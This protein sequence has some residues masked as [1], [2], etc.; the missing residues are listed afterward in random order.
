[1]TY[2]IRL[3]LLLTLFSALFSFQSHAQQQPAVQH[4]HDLFQTIE[5]AYQRGELNL[6]QKVLYQFYA[7][8]Q[9]TRLPAEFKPAGDVIMKCGTPAMTSFINNRDQLSPATINQVESM[10]RTISPQSSESYQSSSGKFTIHYQTSGSGAV[11]P[12]DQNNNG[13]PDYVEE[14]A[15]AADSSYRHEVQR[16]GYT[17]AIVGNSD[18]YPIFIENTS[19]NYGFTDLGYRRNLKSDTFI[20]VHN[21][22]ENF[23]ENDDPEGDQI[24]SLKVTIAHELKHA[25]Q[26]EANQWQGETERWL[27]MDATLMEEVVYDD[28][29]DYYNYLASEQSIFNSPGQN[30]Y[31]GSYFHVSWALYF[32]ERYGSQ[33][34]VDVWEIIKS[35]PSI[36]M[37]NALTQQLGGQEAFARNFT[38][39]QLWHLAAGA[40]A[41]P[42]FGFEESSEY[43]TPEISY[44]F[45]GEESLADPDT[46]NDFSASYFDIQP[47]SFPGTIAFNFSDLM[48]PRPG[49]GILAY[50]EDGSVEP[51][52]LFENQQSTLRYS[53]P[54]QWDEIQKIG[55][56]AANSSLQ[57]FTKY[58]FAISSADPQVVSVK[59][60]YPNPFSEQTTI[61]YSLPAQKHVQL[62][63]YDIL[64]RKVATLVDDVQ[65]KGVYPEKFN[66]E[67][68][69]SGIYIYRITIDG[70]VTTK[71]M[72]LIK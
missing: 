70:E 43:P 9:P 27:E 35:N 40:N 55:L 24:G 42:A 10:S 20:A 19:P 47:V 41:T 6:D 48:P 5:K 63:V 13:I 38:A 51:V 18:P 54:W 3:L 11:P 72:T 45:V 12:D 58:G 2:C 17:D 36:T 61:R 66:A 34:W 39:S 7:T 37:V 46:L 57:Q 25:I 15:A 49:F 1:M 31:P 60:N 21:D 32:E 44:N 68:L 28:V 4:Q 71:K 22:F 33:F 67:G 59:Q 65:P 16:L 56:V 14:A 23:P 64:G 50:F 26:Y 69:A 29:N 52:I 30:F 53:T 8:R 62:E